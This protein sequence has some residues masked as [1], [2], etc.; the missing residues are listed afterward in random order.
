[1]KTIYYVLGIVL[2]I[3]F[4]SC[5]SKKNDND[6]E[7]VADEHQYTTDAPQPSTS[8]LFRSDTMVVVGHD[9]IVSIDRKT[10]ESLPRVKD[11][12]DVVFFDNSVAVTINENGGTVF[13]RTFTKADFESY[14]SDADRAVCVFQG[15]ALDRDHS[16]STSVCLGAQLGQPGLD[17]EGPA[18]NVFISTT[19]GKVKIEK[20]TKPF[21][22]LD[23][24]TGEED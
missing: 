4:A 9:Y 18:F 12:N 15:M 1:M 19:D 5:Q 17:G 20:V 14:L 16:V 2:T 22:T 13:E 3:V 11:E 6:S 7:S 10:D 23:E 8:N 21:T 24:M